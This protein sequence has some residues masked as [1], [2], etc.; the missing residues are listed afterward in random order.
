MSEK[1]HRIPG[2]A[3]LALCAMAMLA[4]CTN[5]V[6][7][8][9]NVLPR[10][11]DTAVVDTA[12][13][14]DTVADLAEDATAADTVCAC[15][16]P[17]QW[18]RFDALK[19]ET[20]DGAPHPVTGTLN[21]LWLKDIK[22]FELN[23][24]FE[25]T[26]VSATEVEFRVINAAR[27]GTAG[28]TCLLPDTETTVVFPR[29][30]CQLLLS[31]ETGINVYAGTQKNVKNCSIG[32]TSFPGSGGKTVRHVIPVRK[33][34]LSA[35]IAQGCGAIA[36]GKVESGSFSKFALEN[37]CTCLVTGKDP[38]TGKDNNS[39]ICLSP[40]PAFKGE[41]DECNGCSDSFQSLSKLLNA[42]G[43]LEYKCKTDADEP[44]ACLQASFSAQRIDAPPALCP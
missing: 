38:A 18:F 1:L 29:K 34:R 15:L 24:F 39:D 5:P 44:A 22:A 8:R 17:G 14:G 26:K 19:L 40:D 42:F 13:A 12:D 3:S 27:V 20:I 33:A 35:D 7:D 21:N 32:T 36:N 11:E 43:E 4:A 2:L 37:T 41:G 16:Q 9:E 23:F 30:D 31:A 10:A 25:T 28:A 6:D